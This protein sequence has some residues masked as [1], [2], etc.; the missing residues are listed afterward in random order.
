M[1]TK[2]NYYHTFHFGLAS[3]NATTTTTSKTR[4]TVFILTPL[5]PVQTEKQQLLSVFFRRTKAT[6]PNTIGMWNAR[7]TR[8][9][10]KNVSRSLIGQFMLCLLFEIDTD[11]M[12]EA[13]SGRRTVTKP[14]SLEFSQTN[15]LSMTMINVSYKMLTNFES[16]F[17]IRLCSTKKKGKL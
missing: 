14:N 4:Q 7:V 9:L 3:T 11:R 8:A 16:N 2:D 10:T 17:G 13:I 6:G 1:I 15:Y 5:L 12:Y